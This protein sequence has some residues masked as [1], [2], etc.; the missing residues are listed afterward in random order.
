MCREEEVCREDIGVEIGSILRGY[1][2]TL[3]F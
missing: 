1:S 2:L 3:W